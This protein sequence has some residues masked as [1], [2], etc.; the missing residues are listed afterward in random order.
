MNYNEE[1][2]EKVKALADYIVASA[3]PRM[4]WMWGEALLGYALDEMD[5]ER[6]TTDYVEFLKAYCDYWAKVDPAIDQSDPAA[7]VLSPTRCISVRKIPSIKGLP[8]RCLTTYDTS[9]GSILIAS[10]T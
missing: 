7:P 5:K 9:R 8:T 10:T 1:L 2:F 3:D 4:K 6:D